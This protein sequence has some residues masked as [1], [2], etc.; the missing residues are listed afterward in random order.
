MLTLPRDPAPY[1]VSR[2][3]TPV[4]GRFPD[5]E[6]LYCL[7]GGSNTFGSYGSGMQGLAVGAAEVLV[8][9][10]DKLRLYDFTP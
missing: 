4:R 1:P 6:P 10:N 8:A 3:P 5:R 9:F 7:R 2:D